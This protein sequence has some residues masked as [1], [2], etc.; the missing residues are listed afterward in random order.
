MDA[1]ERKAELLA[2]AEN[3]REI[4]TYEVKHCLE[5]AHG[6]SGLIAN[7]AARL[8]ALADAEGEP[9]NPCD[10]CDREAA[11]IC[12]C[13]NYTRYL[14]NRP[15]TITT[16][17]G[18]DAEPEDVALEWES[19]PEKA[20]QLGFAARITGSALLEAIE[21]SEQPD[22]SWG[23][24]ARYN[25][26]AHT[27]RASWWMLSRNNEAEAKQAAQ[28]WLNGEIALLRGEAPK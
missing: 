27:K 12:P 11:T 26:P 2:I 20:P 16:Q 6:T 24:Y 4:Q 15:S 8:Q 28:D 18:T 7:L 17:T 23:V 22:R 1:K 9:E 5:C 19:F 13:L 3:L 25:C 10:G 14:K 21:V